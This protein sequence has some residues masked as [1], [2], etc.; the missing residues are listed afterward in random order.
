[1][2]S[3]AYLVFGV[4]EHKKFFGKKYDSPVF[5][6]NGKEKNKYYADIYNGIKSKE[7]NALNGVE[8]KEKQV[9]QF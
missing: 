5:Y 1:M 3:N 6:V 4:M 8:F 7:I 9:R 2:F